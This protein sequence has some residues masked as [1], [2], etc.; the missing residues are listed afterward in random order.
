[1]FV[2][3]LQMSLSQLCL[4]NEIIVRL[5]VYVIQIKWR[6]YIET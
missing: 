6:I 5:S 3:S 2:A 4:I 1:M